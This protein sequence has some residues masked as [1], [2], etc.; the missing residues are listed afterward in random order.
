LFE[1]L[2]RIDSLETSP[3][4]D[5]SATVFAGRPGLGVSKSTDGGDTWQPANAGLALDAL[6]GPSL[7]LSPDFHVDN[8]VFAATLLGLFESTD[9]AATWQPVAITSA[10]SDAPTEEL[11]V[12]PA[13]GTD[14]TML[15]SVRGHGLFKSTDGG[16]SWNEVAPDLIANNELLERIRF[17]PAFPADGV[18]FGYS[19]TRLYRSDDG[20]LSWSASSQGWIRQENHSPAD[21]A[22][23]YDGTGAGVVWPSAS[24]GRVT[25]L[26]TSS[27]RATFYVYGTGVRWVGARAPFLGIASVHL[28]GVLQATVDQYGASPEPQVILFETTGLPAGPHKLEIVVTGQK[29]PSATGIGASIDAIDFTR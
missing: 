17:S 27:S 28:D 19:S 14:G 7:R 22:L 12:S 24:A 3:I 20:G 29:N 2:A 21:Q 26:Q 15:A 6:R 11:A 9:G 10:A 18:V 1:A 4:F 8:H 25:W 5:A 13:F 23:V 16:S